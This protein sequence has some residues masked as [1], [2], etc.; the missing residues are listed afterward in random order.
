VRKN[1]NGRTPTAR[2]RYFR[3]SSQTRGESRYHLQLGPYSS[4]ISCDGAG[5]R[6]SAINSRGK[7]CTASSSAFCFSLSPPQ[8]DKNRIPGPAIPHNHIPLEN[9]TRYCARYAHDH[10]VVPPDCL[11]ALRA[12]T[13]AN[14]PK[15][16]TTC[17]SLTQEPRV[18]SITSP[19]SSH[20]CHRP[21][22]PTV[23]LPLCLSVCLP[24]AA[25]ARAP[26]SYT[27]YAHIVHA[28]APR[29]TL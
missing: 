20:H 1:L 17:S 19:T 23:S 6:T 11:D 18:P 12:R 5:A 4:V 22:S 21:S 8:G 29:P 2:P 16:P 3:L 9:T 15:S 27:T 28:C 26:I 7:H 24:L 13:G 25:S 10:H 14:R